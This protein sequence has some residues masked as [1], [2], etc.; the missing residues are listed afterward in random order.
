M[1]VAYAATLEGPFKEDSAS[2]AAEA[3]AEAAADAAIN[4]VEGVLARAA[5]RMA[6]ASLVRSKI[7]EETIV[8]LWRQYVKQAG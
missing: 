6:C 3:V 7:K 8:G 1:C 5:W 2:A 4:H